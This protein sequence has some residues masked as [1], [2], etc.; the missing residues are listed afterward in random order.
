MLRTLPALIL[1]LMANGMGEMLGYA[2]GAGDAKAKRAAL[3]YGRERFLNR[4]D[5]LSFG[6]M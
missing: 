1:G 4:S 6:Y 2:F 5:R 3:E